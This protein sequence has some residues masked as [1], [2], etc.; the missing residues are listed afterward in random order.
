[1]KS[2]SGGNQQRVALARW[3]SQ[4]P[5]VLVLN[6]PS[7]GVDVGSKADIHEMIRELAMSGIGVVVISDD[8]PELLATCGRILVMKDGRIDSTVKAGAINEIELAARLAS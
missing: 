3:L 5:R 7:V 6:G 1:M 8:L 4:T 2:L